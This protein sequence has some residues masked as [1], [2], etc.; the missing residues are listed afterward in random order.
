MQPFN[1]KRLKA[2]LWKDLESANN[3]VSAQEAGNILKI[4]F[5]LS[6]SPHFIRASVIT[7]RR[8]L[9]TAVSIK[10]NYC[11]FPYS[12]REDYVNLMKNVTNSN[13]KIDI[14]GE[15]GNMTL[16]DKNG[17][18]HRNAGY[19]ELAKDYKFYLSLENSL[20]TEYVTE[21]FFNALRYGILPITN[22]KDVA[23]IAPPHSYLHIN[24]F[25]SPEDLMK[26][27]QNLSQNEE[28][29]N[30]YFWWNEFYT[31]KIDNE[32]KPQCKFCDILNNDNF[33]S[34]NDYS[35]LITYWNKC[36]TP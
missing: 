33:K 36:D 4:G 30:S 1:P 31:V 19:Q 6:K 25:N 29:Y 17:A 28:L 12:R 18:D 16:I 7:V 26:C 3:I 24:D 14:F 32:I 5:V 8:V 10:L 9:S 13:L 2:P 20:C 34:V 11:F 21:K 35:Q 23:K 15:C 27:L 22:A